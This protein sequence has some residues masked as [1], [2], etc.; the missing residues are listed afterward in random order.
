MNVIS[1][2]FW[3]SKAKYVAEKICEEL[4]FIPLVLILITVIYGVKILT[5][6]QVKIDIS[7]S[8]FIFFYH[9]IICYFSSKIISHSL[10][11]HSFF[12]FFGLFVSL[13]LKIFLYCIYSGW[14][15]QQINAFAQSAVFNGKSLETDSPMQGRYHLKNVILTAMWVRKQVSS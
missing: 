14:Q 9:L 11:P 2:N 13:K 15:K 1:C 12:F 8:Y 7:S 4:A 6:V 5:K 3:D 10:S